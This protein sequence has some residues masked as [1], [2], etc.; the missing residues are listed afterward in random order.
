MKHYISFIITV[1]GDTGWRFYN[2]AQ[3][4]SGQGCLL[5]DD[6]IWTREQIKAAMERLDKSIDTRHCATY[7]D[8]HDEGMKQIVKFVNG[9][10][11]VYVMKDYATPRKGWP[12]IVC[13]TIECGD[14][15][16]GKVKKI[17]WKNVEN[18]D[19]KKKY[20]EDFE[21]D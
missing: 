21:G 11:G 16:E 2:S 14:Y 9:N 12:S 3:W 10:A 1:G 13:H 19:P 5:F 8:T 20:P 7:S 15:T 6:S 17:D 18:Y 4:H